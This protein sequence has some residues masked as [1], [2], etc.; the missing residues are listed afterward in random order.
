MFGRCGLKKTQARM[1]IVYD[2]EKKKNK[3]VKTKVITKCTLKK[4][5]K[6]PH[7]Y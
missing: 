3:T 1:Q 5:H 4:G 7:N 6:G 2:V